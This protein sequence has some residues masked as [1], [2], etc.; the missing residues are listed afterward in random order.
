MNIQS[1]QNEVTQSSQAT[2]LKLN[3]PDKVVKKLEIQAEAAKR[4]R[5][6]NLNDAL[7]MLRR[8]AEIFNK[9]LRF[10]VH[11]ITGRVVVKVIDGN[12]DTVIRQLPPEEVLRFL[13]EVHKM[14][15]IFIDHE[16]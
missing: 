1:L 9:R 10:S 12:T 5:Q 16:V 11:D 15:G 7:E 3:T 2:T 8:A 13:E 14:I 4:Y 6:V